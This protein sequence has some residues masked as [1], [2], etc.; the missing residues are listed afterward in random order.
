[1]KKIL[2]VLLIPLLISCNGLFNSRNIKF[3]TIADKT[4]VA[5]K[6]TF[7]ED[8][9]N[10][11]RIDW[12]E[13]DPIRIAS[14]HTIQSYGNYNVINIKVK[15]KRSVGKLMNVD[16]QVLQWDEKNT[17]TYNFWSV[18]PKSAAD[19]LMEDGYNGEITANIPVDEYLMVAHSTAQYGSG[20]VNLL[21]YPAFTT[22]RFSL[23]SDIEGV[24]LNS[25]KLS[26]TN[27]LE[28]T[29]SG[30]IDGIINKTSQ[31][32]VSD[33]SKVIEIVKQTGL[34]QTDGTEMLFFC[35]PH[36][37]AGVKLTCNFT[38][39]G[40]TMEKTLNLD[41]Q[42]GASKQY[43]F[44]LKLNTNKELV[45]TDG[46]IEIV[47]CCSNITYNGN[48][49]R[50][51]S[52]DQ[53][54]ELLRTS[55]RLQADFINF[56]QNTTVLH[57]QQTL[58][59]SNQQTH[60][61]IIRPEDFKAFKNLQRIEYI[62]LS[63]NAEIYVEDLSIDLA[64]FNHGMHY[65]IKDCQNLTSLKLL[66]INNNNSIIEI[67]NCNGITQIE[68]SMI[69]GNNIGCDFVIKNMTSLQSF[70]IH[71]AKSLTFINCPALET[72]TLDRASR[73]ESINFDSLPL[74]KTG[75][76]ISVDKNVSVSLKDC[77]T[78]ITNGTITLRGNGNAT[79]TKKENSDNIS[80]KFIDNGG[81]TKANF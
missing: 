40:E 53:V 18:Y 24:T 57:S 61:V 36:N 81:N 44:Y 5:T 43:R 37:I 50:N 14:D 80:V 55:E 19:E 76:F 30:T 2:L 45:F 77:G 47:R 58:D 56:V 64:Y 13:G 15:N 69:E 9:A 4:N 10:F 31:I 62:D 28:G 6:A 52:H 72:I 75:S 26:S 70:S 49:I 63:S 65:V 39:G 27:Y 48:F 74:F 42:F 7:G 32:E 38:V 33:G 68:A 8:Y 73:L 60:I 34:S 79:N 78:Q 29:F 35:L 21:F 71:D 51:F 67:D 11:Q 46:L 1:M 23:I 66:N 20:E 16:G 41:Y 22:F 3:V 59:G 17:G 25:V 54:K 12:E